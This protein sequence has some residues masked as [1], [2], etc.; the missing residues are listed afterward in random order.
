MLLD[1]NPTLQRSSRRRADRA[2]HGRQT[3]IRRS[4]DLHEER[5]IALHVAIGSVKLGRL[6]GL[7]RAISPR[8]DHRPLNLISDTC[9]NC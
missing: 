4:R 7:D 6:D 5:Q 1:L 9:L 3:G 2:S 8:C